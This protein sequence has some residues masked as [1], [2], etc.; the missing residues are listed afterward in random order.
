ME[1][2]IVKAEKIAI[3]IDTMGAALKAIM[4]NKNNNMPA[5][6]VSTYF[7]NLP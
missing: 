7:H 2:P 6:T 4:D 5:T 3:K 1:E